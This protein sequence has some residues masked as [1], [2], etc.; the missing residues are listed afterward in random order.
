MNFKSYM[1]MQ[2]NNYLINNDPNDFTITRIPKHDTFD[3]NFTIQ[4][5][6]LIYWV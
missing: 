3:N 5:I 6:Y 1:C 2:S 4:N